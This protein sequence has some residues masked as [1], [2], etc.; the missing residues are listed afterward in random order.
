[1]KRRQ[2]I[3]IAAGAASMAL[4]ATGSNAAGQAMTVYRDPSC[5]CCH[6]W[7]EAMT[8]AGF[9]I[10]SQDMEDMTTIKTRYGVPE[11]LQACH[12]AV[13]DGYFI[14]GHV[15]VEAVTKLLLERPAIAGL[16]VPGMPA[17]SLGMG[18]DP[19]ATYDVLAVMADSARSHSVYMTVGPKK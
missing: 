13:V 19:E 17:G 5:G 3:C 9:A 4:T 10:D 12:T 18:D 6:A 15:P 2:F 16:T 8:G 14:E 1:M 7:M 11:A